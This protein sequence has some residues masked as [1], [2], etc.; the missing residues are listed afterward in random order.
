MKSPQTRQ[1]TCVPCIGRWVLNHWTTREALEV[2]FRDNY[3]KTLHL[4]GNEVMHL[5]FSSCSAWAQKLW[6]KGSVALRHVG[7]SQT[8]DQ[9]HAPVLAGGFLT[10]EPPG[11]P[12]AEF[13]MMRMGTGKARGR[14][15]QAGI[16]GCM[17]EQDGAAWQVCWGCL[18]LAAGLACYLLH[19]LTSLCP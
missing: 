12:W 18:C 4:P 6:H 13:W 3:P 11:K 17:M 8:R 15:H 5:N 2:C 19:E 9:T 7:S 1:R 14:P 10:T 16:Q